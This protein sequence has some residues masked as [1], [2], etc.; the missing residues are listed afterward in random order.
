M[1]RR[2]AAALGG[3][4]AFLM[5][6]ARRGTP[7]A[8]PQGQALAAAAA[9]GLAS[10]VVARLVEAGLGLPQA[11]AEDAAMMAAIAGAADAAQTGRWDEL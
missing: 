9:D 3:W 4:V 11:I 5:I 1:P 8:D 6:S 7:I 2:V 10:Q